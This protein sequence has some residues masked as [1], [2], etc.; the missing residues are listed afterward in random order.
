VRIRYLTRAFADLEAIYAYIAKRN[1]KAAIQTTAAIR[2]S[3]DSLA[4]FP[5]IGQLANRTN[6]RVLHSA[7]HNYKIYY[8]IIE[9]QVQILHIRH[10]AR[11]PP[12]E[13]EL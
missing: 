7:H 13:D 6:V 1:P 5:E 9:D 12:T 4:Y 11:K 8:S 10:A 3:I 2:A